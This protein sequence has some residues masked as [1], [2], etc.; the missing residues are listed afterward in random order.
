MHINV[1]LDI[2]LKSILKVPGGR[3]FLFIVSLCHCCK[4]ILFSTMFSNRSSA[5]LTAEIY[6]LTD[7]ALVKMGCG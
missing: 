6:H 5:V 4:F 3:F 2:E 1:V 7:H